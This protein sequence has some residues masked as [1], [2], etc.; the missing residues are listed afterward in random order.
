MYFSNYGKNY[1]GSFAAVLTTITSK[2]D[3][4]FDWISIDIHR[5]REKENEKQVKFS[6]F[7]C[8]LFFIDGRGEI[9]FCQF[10]LR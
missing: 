1:D 6:Y 2:N 10:T 7:K 5:P 9:H 3:Q 8:E 4:I